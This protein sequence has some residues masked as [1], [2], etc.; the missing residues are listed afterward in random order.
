M[1]QYLKDE[2][3]KGDRELLIVVPSDST[4]ESD[5]WRT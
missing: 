3:S 4:A 5:L 2:M 1:V